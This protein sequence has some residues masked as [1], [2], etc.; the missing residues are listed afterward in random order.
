MI[1]SKNRVLITGAGSGLGRQLAIDYSKMGWHVILV[2]RT[3]Q[4]LIE[5]QPL[6]NNDNTIIQCDISNI[7]DVK[8]L[9]NKVLEEFKGID[10]VINNAGVFTSGLISKTDLDVYK[11]VFNVNITGTLSIC[12][13]FVPLLKKQRYGYIVNVSSGVGLIPLPYMGI[14]GI[15]K[16]SIIHLSEVLKMELYKD[17]INVS[18]V[19]PSF[20][21]SNILDNSKGLTEKQLSLGNKLLEESNNNIEYISN[22]IIKGIKK[23]KF[24][25]FINYKDR[26]FWFLKRLFPNI[27]IKA[28]TYYYIKKV[29]K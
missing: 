26:V 25:I 6:L 29:I 3:K 4:H 7:E 24:Y 28:L 16:S 21:K 10:V 2:G 5:T 14:Y 9:Y 19:C 1:V 18:V 17:N 11:D 22:K 27:F 15:T 13:T 8:N 20:F 23:K 12:R